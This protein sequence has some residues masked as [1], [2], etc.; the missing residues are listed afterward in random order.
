MIQNLHLKNGFLSVNLC[1]K[2]SCIQILKKEWEVAWFL[3][4]IS[5]RRQLFLQTYFR[6]FNNFKVLRVVVYVWCSFS[7]TLFQ[8]QMVHNTAHLHKIELITKKT[9]KLYFYVI[10]LMDIYLICH[11]IYYT[12]VLFFSIVFKRILYFMSN[13][14]CPLFS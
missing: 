9:F 5:C 2:S 3:Y 13:K 6:R 1:F 12:K 11:T 4:S 7:Q 10:L 14:S 8:C